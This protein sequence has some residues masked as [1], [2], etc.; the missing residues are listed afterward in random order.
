MYHIVASVS[1]LAICTRGRGSGHWKWSD[2]SD[3][4]DSVLAW[5]VPTSC[6]PPDYSP[7]PKT[8]NRRGH[9]F[10]MVDV[11]ASPRM[12]KLARRRLFPRHRG[13]PSPA[14][15]LVHHAAVEECPSSA[16]CLSNLTVAL[17]SS[18]SSVTGYRWAWLGV[19]KSRSKNPNISSCSTQFSRATTGARGLVRPAAS[20]QLR[21]RGRQALL[22]SSPPPHR[23]V[24]FRRGHVLYH[25]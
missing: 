10:E 12:I 11:K 17:K 21:E 2:S 16:P 19:L 1:L 25:H 20:D 7:K 23:P 22:P 4:S 18:H 5:G 15:T 24:E 9:W 8:N 6:K 3:S 14:I 13:I